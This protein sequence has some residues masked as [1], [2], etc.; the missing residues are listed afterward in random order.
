M[1][2]PNFFFRRTCSKAKADLNLSLFTLVLGK[3]LRQEV[4][5]SCV[6]V[7]QIQP[8]LQLTAITDQFTGFEQVTRAGCDAL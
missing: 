6:K 7:G 4:K 5:E 3:K 2:P 1:Q 8:L